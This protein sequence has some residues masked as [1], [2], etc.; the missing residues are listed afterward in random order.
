MQD[1]VPFFNC[2]TI[3]VQYTIMYYNT[4]NYRK[5][6]AN[7]K[8]LEIFYTFEYFFYKFGVFLTGLDNSL[9]TSSHIKEDK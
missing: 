3:Q 4:N 1:T 5:Q 7:T 2:T 8:M 6:H 9:T